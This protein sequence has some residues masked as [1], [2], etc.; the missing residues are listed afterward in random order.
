MEEPRVYLIKE[1]KKLKEFLE[2]VSDYKL[3]DIE[4]E[5]RASLLDDMLESK[6]E[7]LK[8]AMKKLEENEIDE[9]KL[10]LKGGNALLVL[11][12]ED[13]ISI[14][15]VFEDAHGVIQALEING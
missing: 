5:N 12:I 11:K 15:L 4:I 1:I 9:A 6:D 14:R 7:K 8:Y 3:L 13:V 2:K 10:V